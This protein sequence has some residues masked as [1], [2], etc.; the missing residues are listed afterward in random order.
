[1]E[2]K[3]SSS[4]LGIAFATYLVLAMLLLGLGLHLFVDG[5][6]YVEAQ[7]ITDQITSAYNET[8]QDV[9]TV[10]MAV[11]ERPQGVV[12]FREADETGAHIWATTASFEKGQMA[13]A[14]VVA[15]W[16]AQ[17]APV[18]RSIPEADVCTPTVENVYAFD[19]KWHSADAFVVG[20]TNA[21]SVAVMVGAGSMALLA[22]VVWF[23]RRVRRLHDVRRYFVDTP[24]FFFTV[25]EAA[26]M[27]TVGVVG[28]VLIAYIAA[29][30]QIAAA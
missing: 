20:Y 15:Y 13:G 27:V 7:R 12:A 9:S 16:D 19:G 18:F 21:F 4:R 22:A 26:L 3:T 5:E 14:C 11:G 24:N 30:V 17:H 2:N 25:S 1:M 23:S 6:S 8:M 10:A 28:S 29:G